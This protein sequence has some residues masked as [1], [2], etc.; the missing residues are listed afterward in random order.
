MTSEVTRANTG[1]LRRTVLFGVMA[2]GLAACAGPAP[3][4]SLLNEASRSNLRIT[5]VVVDVSN[6]GEKT[7]GRA[8]S[9]ESVKSLVTQSANVMLRGQGNGPRAARAE[10]SVDDVN[11]ITAGQSM[12]IGGESTMTG[13]LSLVDPRTG[14]VLLPPAKVS[15]GGGGWAAGGII[16]V[17]TRDDAS[18]EL[19]QMSQEFV[20]RSRILVFGA[21]PGQAPSTT[22]RNTISTSSGSSSEQVSGNDAAV[23]RAELEARAKHDGPCHTLACEQDIARARKAAKQN[24]N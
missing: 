13:S 24:S 6:M 20:A 7:K 23:R 22:S 17:A 8:V 18:T 4:E 5:E 11:I 16:A 2:V 3:K 1:M 21:P 12:L 15:S 9:S 19:R 14:D 10:L